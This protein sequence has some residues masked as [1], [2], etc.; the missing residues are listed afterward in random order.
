MG[1]TAI[2]DPQLEE[3]MQSAAVE[4]KAVR[5]SVDQYGQRL[6]VLY[7]ATLALTV[8]PAIGSA[9]CFLYVL[10]VHVWPVAVP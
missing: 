3:Q 4:W 9:A 2:L 8:L 1:S 5:T 6:A 7:P 10:A